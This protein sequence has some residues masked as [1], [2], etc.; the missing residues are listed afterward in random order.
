MTTATSPQ[1][2][3]TSCPS[4]GV[5]V[6]PD[7]QSALAYQEVAFECEQR[8][9]FSSGHMTDHALHNDNCWVC[10]D[11]MSIAPGIVPA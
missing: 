1:F 11:E 10:C 2:L 6:A 4:H 9:L 8:R 5:T 7:A 3:V